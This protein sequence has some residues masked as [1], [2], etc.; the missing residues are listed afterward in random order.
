[1]EVRRFSYICIIETSLIHRS[2]YKT[3]LVAFLLA[4]FFQLSAQENFELRG[5]IIDSKQKPLELAI[6]RLFTSKNSS[7][8]SSAFTEK[9][10]EFIFPKI[11]ADEYYISVEFLGFKKHI[12]DKK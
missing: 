6:V 4:N 8:I 1:M 5:K 11:E 2:Y 12:S 9:N 10:G 7:L 3:I